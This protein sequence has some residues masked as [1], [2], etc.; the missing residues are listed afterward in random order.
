MSPSS[1]SNAGATRAGISA[2]PSSPNSGL[3]PIFVL[4]ICAS[5]F[6]P[7]I[8]FYVWQRRASAV[9]SISAYFIPIARR[10]RN[11]EGDPANGRPEMFNAWTEQGASNSRLKWEEYMVS[12]TAPFR[13]GNIRR[14]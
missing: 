14:L 1:L 8:S 3:P 9:Q 10:R 6:T 4:L 13:V 2:R 11:N 5:V 12:A 7:L